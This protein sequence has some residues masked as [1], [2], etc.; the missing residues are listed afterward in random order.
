MNHGSIRITHSPAFDITLSSQQPAEKGFSD[1]NLVPRL[2]RAGRR[3]DMMVDLSSSR[4]HFCRI[5]CIW[6]FEV[7]LQ[8]RRQRSFRN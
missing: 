6:R 4:R 1:R 8:L 5:M 7:I 2:P 3:P